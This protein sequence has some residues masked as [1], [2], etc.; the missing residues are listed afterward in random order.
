[1]TFGTSGAACCSNEDTATLDLDVFAF[2]LLDG[3]SFYGDAL[4]PASEVGGVAEQPKSR[5]ALP[6]TEA[7]IDK[8]RKQSVPKKTLPTV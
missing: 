3:R 6:K 2:D 8:A 5:F 7:E 1:M 4:F